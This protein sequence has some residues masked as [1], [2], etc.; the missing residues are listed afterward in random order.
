[1]KKLYAFLIMLVAFGLISTGVVRA[2]TYSMRSYLV[3]MITTP[4]AQGLGSGPNWSAI[5]GTAVSGLGYYY[6]MSPS[7]T[8]PFAFRFENQQIATTGNFEVNS[9][10][11]VI[12]SPT[13]TANY[14]YDY[15]ADFFYLSEY[16]YVYEDYEYDFLESEYDYAPYESYYPNYKLAPFEGF[17]T[18]GPAPNCSY[19][20]LG[21][22]PNRELVVQ[23][24]GLYA[25]EY[26]SSAGLNGD[27]QAVVYE[28]GI[29]SF[30]FNYGP[31]SGTFNS[32]W[33]YYY[34]Y[35]GWLI[36]AYSGLTGIK[37]SG[38][39]DF[40]TIGWNGN[41][42]NPSNQPIVDYYGYAEDNATE[43]LLPQ[44][45]YR[46]A[47]AWPYN[48]TA[49]TI[50]NPA[51]ETPQAIN[52]YFTPTAILANSGSQ[53]STSCQVNF[54]ISEYGVGQ[55]YN[56][57]ITLNSSQIP[58]GFSQTTITF[59]AFAPGEPAQFG[60][61]QS[62]GYGIYEDTMTVFNLQPTADQDPSDNQS[63][64]EWTCAPPND[65]KGVSVINPPAGSR[66]QVDIAT[67]ISIRFR[68][69]GTDTQ[70]NVPVTATVHDATGKVVFRDTVVIPYWPSGPMGGNS[71]GVTDYS[72]SGQGPGRGAY[73]D[74]AFPSSPTWT[75]VTL[76]VDTV[77]GIAIMGNDQL[78]ADDTTKSPTP[79][80]P[81]YDAASVGVFNPQPGEEKPYLTTWQPSALFQSVGVSD[82]FSFKI[83]CQIRRCSDGLLA[84]QSDTV[85]DALNI[86][87]GQ[88][89]FKFP[90]T[91]NAGAYHTIAT[92]PPGCY[93]LCAIAD[94]SSSAGS[95]ENQ[96]ND[97]SCTQFSIIDRLKGDY[98]VGVG[99]QFQTIHQA[100]DTM[101]FRG[102]GANVRMI[103]TDA[104]YTENGN[105]DV[106]SPYG[107]VDLGQI[108]GLSASSTVTWIPYPG[109]N[110][111]ITFSGSQPFCFYMGDHFPGYMNFEG[112]NPSTVPSPD[113]VTAEPLKR[114]LTIVSNETK[115]GAVFGIEYG[116][117][118]ITLKDLVIHGNGMFANDS[119]SAVRI[120]NEHNFFVYSSGIHDTVA[121][122]NITV[123]NCELGNAKYG[124]YDHGYH[125]AY[126]PV[127]GAYTT[128]RNYN[129]VI[130][131]NTV[132]TSSNPLSYAGIQFNSETGIVIS[133]NEISNV[134]ANVV[135]Q[136]GGATWNV[137]GIVQPNM[138]TYIGPPSNPQ[139]AGDTGNV[140]GA[141]IDAN[142]I[143]I[144]TSAA[145]NTHGIALQ[146]SSWQYTSTG[147]T[148]VK[149][150]LPAVT[151]NRLTNNMILDLRTSA[152]KVF[153]ILMTT[154]SS[155]SGTVPYST[156]KDS[157]FNNS[158]STNNAT[159]NITIKYAKHAFI[160]NN[161]FQ[162]TGTGP[163]TNYNLEVPRPYASSISSDY[164]VFDLRGTNVF[165]S[166][167]EYDARY[168]TVF[169]SLYFR[170]LNDWRTYVGQDSHSLSGDPLF[171]T[172]AMGV[173]SLHMPP[174]L[175]YIESPAS[176]NGAWLG[177][178]SEAHDFDGDVRS[179]N[180]PSPDIGADE[181]D[182][183]QFTNDL[184][185]LEISQPGGFSQTSDTSLVTT[186]SP[187]WITGVVKNLSSVGVYSQKV[188]ATVQ[189]S[190]NGVWTTV[191]TGT[192]APLTWQVGESKSVAFQGPALTA[193]N[194]T[195][196]FRVTVS[197]PN[198]QNDANNSQT[199]TF[200]ILL[201]QNAVLLSYNGAASDGRQNRDS[202]IA[203]LN[204]LGVP[205]DTIDRNAPKGLPNTTIIDYTPW[206][207]I[208]WSSGDPGVAP[209]AGQSTGQGGP[210]LQETDEIT[211]YL[212]AG[213]SYAKKSL[214]I[215]GQHI[216][217]Y[218]G[219]VQSNNPV[220]DTQWMQSTMHTQYV[221]NYPTSSSYIGRIVGQQPAYWTFADSLSIPVN[222]NG[223]DCEE[224]STD[225]TSSLTPNVI[226]PSLT[227]PAVGPKVNGYAYT[228]SN[229]S[230]SNPNN[231][232]GVS[233]YDPL[234]NTVFYA[235]DWANPHQTSPSTAAQDA[236]TSGTTR[237]LA[238][239]FAFFRSHN[240]TILPIDNVSA[241]I[242]RVS[243]NAA[244]ITWDVVGL[245]NVVRY[246]VEQQNQNSWTVLH[247]V[248]AVADQTD[249]ASSITGLDPSQSY[250]YR[251]AAVDETGAETYSNTV[252][253]GPDA[254][255]L[256]FTLGQSY[257]N[258]SAGVT[259]VS[260]TLPEASQVTL[261][262]MDVTGKVVNSEVTNQSFEAGTQN[263]KLDLTSLPSGSYL[264][265]M[266]AT[267][268]DGRSATLSS[269][270]TIE[271]Q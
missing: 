189:R 47:I 223:S 82:L 16:G 229:Y 13:W 104:S 234:V 33:G 120:Y 269:K 121:T 78:R 161:I 1:M 89:L 60:E 170:R 247:P 174:A 180:N 35:G 186:E 206:W 30:Q 86:D 72:S 248:T 251:I 50:T 87:Q 55:V 227:T 134:N 65:I 256:G 146:Q 61:A 271:K 168:G 192:S 199:K 255:Q 5:S 232:A 263:V 45:S 159:S 90:T 112:Y 92:I 32:S 117:S 76:G 94:F 184:A 220:T 129:D 22:A 175:T 254:S 153:P 127:K 71:D 204:R 216:A 51:S 196:V 197:V 207:T 95:D 160:W 155:T 165:D 183:F 41:G 85:E 124:I 217:Y 200:T 149:S 74:T 84:F 182:G 252:E 163:Y 214:V 147:L 23:T 148:N 109:Q 96:T 93:T 81:L 261:R 4:D 171:G 135:P 250:T 19:A 14:A 34:S 54:T 130:T 97:T 119:C 231:G 152:G 169:Q 228:Y 48:L 31:Q 211:R 133:H 75:P 103:L 209:V 17:L 257:P 191:Y 100:V 43:P 144:M 215:A 237:T 193:S 10:G 70:Y 246:D 131:R 139:W 58:A 67:P 12:F 56:Q 122:S 245:P 26:G 99:R 52:T 178:S 158:I 201:K 210:T 222:P 143:R 114:G 238:A 154:I 166:V 213:Q 236:L 102:I 73:Y 208:V 188:T 126:D 9:Y 176:N 259:E 36:E 69:L 260:F 224:C 241:S 108:N 243:G 187:L 157:V 38:G 79:I 118:N 225:L 111:T 40:L 253:L 265:E 173:D 151:Q 105:T 202:V 270:L 42:G 198:D 8:V 25:Y 64:D 115:A 83:R 218:N 116:A 177:T 181:W 164:N 141:W 11:S 80:L 29:S 264:Y 142:R 98:Y 249:Y 125:D 68:N 221:A 267:G 132:G 37:G 28:S 195:G 230:Y 162:N 240:G 7:Y 46:I 15:D 91:A 107:A 66:T 190:V 136:G 88:V 203:A 44:V 140:T 156:D 194:S 262:V 77:F 138:N 266:T 110:P 205:F 24:L 63:T 242:Q 185:V 258:P 233:Y 3:H 21:S 6:Q 145:G 57:T 2:Q 212:G 18:Y 59:P 128:W 235:F 123:N 20:V 62:T 219:Y 172:P 239:A 167:T 39:G 101:R 226:M 137:Y 244:T 27:F 49:G 179:Q 53:V 113:K 106:A 150:T 268:A